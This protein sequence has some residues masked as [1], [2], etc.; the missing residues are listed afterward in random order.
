[1]NRFINYV[2]LVA[3]IG[4]MYSMSLR[5]PADARPVVSGAPVVQQDPRP[6]IPPN[7]RTF[8]PRCFNEDGSYLNRRGKVRYQR[9]CVWDA[10]RLG[11]REGLSYLYVWTPK[12]DG[13]YYPLTREEARG[14]S[15]R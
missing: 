1:M 2:V 13:R 8:I 12:G 10:R 5:A 4:A 9:V 7:F 11:N 14:L 15:T 6:V 3:M